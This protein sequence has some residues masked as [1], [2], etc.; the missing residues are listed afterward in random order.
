MEEL[1]RRA[2]KLRTVGQLAAGVAHEIRNPL[3]T[4]RGF[5]QLQQRA[6]T[7]ND[8]HT[9]IMLSELER[10]NMIVSEFLILAKPQAVQFEIKD[11]RYT[12]GDVIS[13]LRNNFV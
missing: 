1:L 11:V 5:L 7:V 10:I 6:R 12:V 9:D 2:E 8:T 13:L 3:T 4:L